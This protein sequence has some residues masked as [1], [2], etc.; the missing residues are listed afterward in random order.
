M[1][2]EMTETR[3]LRENPLSRNHSVVFHVINSTTHSKV[4]V[5]TQTE[6]QI[7]QLTRKRILQILASKGTNDGMSGWR[8][9]TLYHK[10]SAYQWRFV[11]NRIIRI[12]GSGFLLS[13]WFAS[14]S[15]AALII[16][17]GFDDRKP[18]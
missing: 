4:E 8:G 12:L 3:K 16:R 1:V 6:R 17:R 10:T 14:K 5:D 18:R 7:T 2:V 11:A 9:T 15:E 13:I